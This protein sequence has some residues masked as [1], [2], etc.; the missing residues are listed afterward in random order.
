VSLQ[1]NAS[2]R[3]LAP[4]GTGRGAVDEPRLLVDGV[5]RGGRVPRRGERRDGT[6][7]E[8]R[9]G[10]ASTSVPMPHHKV[11]GGGAAGCRRR[12]RTEQ[13]REPLRRRRS[14]RQSSSRGDLSL[15]LASELE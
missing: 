3:R 6:A 13:G 5:S 4:A 15:E 8:E 2:S 10:T 9:A 1:A 11:D 14:S 12:T 7:A